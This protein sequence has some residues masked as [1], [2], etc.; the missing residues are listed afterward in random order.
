MFLQKKQRLT[1]SIF[2]YRGIDIWINV[3]PTV[4][5]IF[6]QISGLGEWQV[7]YLEYKAA[8]FGEE[9]GL[10]DYIFCAV[11]QVYGK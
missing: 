10:A 7:S 8:S 2:A 11:E 9:R 6:V 1:R 4:I 3:F 5:A